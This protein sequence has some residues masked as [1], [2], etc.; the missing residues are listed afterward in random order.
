MINLTLEIYLKSRNEVQQ[1]RHLDPLSEYSGETIAGIVFGT[2]VIVLLL[3]LFVILV[4]YRDSM[5]PSSLPPSAC[6]SKCLL[7][8]GDHQPGD[9]YHDQQTG[10][11]ANNK[12]GMI[13]NAG[14]GARHSS[15]QA[16]TNPLT[17]I[18]TNSKYGS[19]DVFSMMTANKGKSIS[20]QEQQQ[21]IDSGHEEGSYESRVSIVPTGTAHT[22]PNSDNLM[23]SAVIRTETDDRQTMALAS[24]DDETDGGRRDSHT[25]L[26]QREEPDFSLRRPKVT[27]VQGKKRAERIADGRKGAQ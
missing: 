13:E 22:L 18:S 24:N 19:F 21:D 16:S 20:S 1:P 26:Q 4:R 2:L 11:R 25:P 5:T 12:I 17:S 8:D 27:G 3:F 10:D 9:H 14:P 15:D 7:D 6:F 23:F